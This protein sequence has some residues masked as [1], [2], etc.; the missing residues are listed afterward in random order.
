MGTLSFSAQEKRHAHFSES[1]QVACFC[2]RGP[3]FPRPSSFSGAAFSE[4]SQIL[5]VPVCKVPIARASE[6]RERGGGAHSGG[7]VRGKRPGGG[8]AQ[9]MWVCSSSVV[10][11]AKRSIHGPF[12]WKMPCRHGFGVF[13]WKLY[14]RSGPVASCRNYLADHFLWS[15]MLVMVTMLIKCLLANYGCDR[16]GLCCASNTRK[17]KARGEELSTN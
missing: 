10:L 11:I 8:G 16:S 12:H 14:Q 5:K 3:A 17:H 9:R 7:F 4:L 1:R 13:S 15:V 6:K 2:Q